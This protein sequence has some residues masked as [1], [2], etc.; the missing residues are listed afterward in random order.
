MS[1]DDTMRN[2]KSLSTVERAFRSI[3]SID[4]KVRPIDDRRENMLAHYVEWHKR[5][6]WAE[7][8]FA[9][10]DQAAKATRDPVAPA[11]RSEMAQTKAQTRRLADRTSAHSFRTLLE[12]LATIVRNTCRVPSSAETLPTF[13][14]VTTPNALQRR[15]RELID[16]PVD[17]NAAAKNRNMPSA[18]GLGKLCLRRKGTSD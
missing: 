5:E 12:E 15:A 2:Y 8:L 3:K 4:L 17:R 14:M 1:A 10:E 18:Q 6:A 9:D 11:Q 7:L 13:A 16:R